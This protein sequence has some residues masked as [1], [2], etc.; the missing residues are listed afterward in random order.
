MAGIS[1]RGWR[2]FSA[3]LCCKLK[4]RMP[5]TALYYITDR[6]VFPGDEAARRR[7]LLVKIAEAARAGVDYVQLREKDLSGRDLEALALAALAAV[8]DA[9]PRTANLQPRTK[10]LINSR[11]DIALAIRADGVH[12]RS[13]D[14]FPSEVRS[15][16]EASSRLVPGTPMVVGESCH[17]PADVQLAQREGADYALFAPVFEKKDAP[18]ARPAGL[19]ALREA[20]Q[21]GIPVFALGGVTVE[22]AAACIE[23][24]ASGI[25]GIRLFQ[26][27]DIAEVV[28][29]V[30]G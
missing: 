22:N 27:H 8:R 19:E 24:G 26:E 18:G 14:V 28:R 23:A 11:T 2:A 21:C 12:L 15:I 16:W 10:L 25:A 5:R 20:C 13:Q 7:A 1:K 4:S 29:N 17:S 30:C 3:P 6:S 9:Q